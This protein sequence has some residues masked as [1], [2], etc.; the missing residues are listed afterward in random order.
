MCYSYTWSRRIL[1]TYIW[2]ERKKETE[3]KEERERK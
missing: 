1:I 3:S 2:E